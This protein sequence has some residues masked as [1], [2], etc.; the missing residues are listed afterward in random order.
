MLDLQKA[1]FF[2]R[3]GA[4]L[5]DLILL[6]ILVTG[7]W[8]MFSEIV[9]YNECTKNLESFYEKYE[10][11]YDVDF[12]ISAEEFEQLPDEELQKYTDANAAMNEDEEAL[13]LYNMKIYMEIMLASA[14]ILLAYTVLEIV[15]PLIL[16]NGQ[17]IGKKVFGLC[18][19]HK[20]GVRVSVIQ[21]CFRALLGK[22]VIETMLP[23]M[24]YL[25]KFYRALGTTGSLIIAVL[26][27]VQ[28]FIIIYS[29][30]NCAIHD[31][32]CNT[33]VVDFHSQ[34]IFDSEEELIAYKEQ[35][36]AEMAARAE[37]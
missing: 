2:K 3:L 7:G 27:M 20:D 19:M 23:V 8:A 33:V 29:R 18:V 26:V 11:L 34:M 9:G 25:L 28:L 17:T 5:L 35:Y 10:Q 21:V 24:I 15:I 37:Y 13:Y 31:K 30:A 32:L 16:K 4:Y 6:V 36:S 1:S 22:Y 12:S 14:S